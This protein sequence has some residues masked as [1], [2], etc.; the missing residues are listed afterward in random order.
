MYFRFANPKG[1]SPT[2]NINSFI[3]YNCTSKKNNL[4]GKTY[5]TIEV[6]EPSLVEVIRS[7]KPPI[8]VANVG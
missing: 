7:C 2:Q 5:R 8:S 3:K 6:I 4:F 1:Y